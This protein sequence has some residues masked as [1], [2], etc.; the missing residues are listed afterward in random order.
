MP[1]FGLTPFLQPGESEEPGE[2]EGVNALLR[3]YSIST[4]CVDSYNIN[5][6]SVSMPFFGLTP[7][8]QYPLGALCLC[9]FPDPFLQVIHRIF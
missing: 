9:G 4:N 7:F 2:S 1:F 8:L 3:A 5:G 6:H